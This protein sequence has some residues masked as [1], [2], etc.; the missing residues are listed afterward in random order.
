MKPHNHYHKKLKT[1]KL[2]A[3]HKNKTNKQQ[4]LFTK[5]MKPIPTPTY[6][7]HLS[8]PWFSLISL[9]LKTV[10]GRKN[11]GIFKSLAVGDTIEWHNEDFKP[12]S[13]LT[14]VVRKTPYPT[15]RE[16]LETEGLQKCLPGMPSVEHGLSVYFKYFTKEQEREFGVMAIELELVM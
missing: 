1:R 5:T 2:A 4:I 3:H 8:E 16:Y 6:R 12:R 7:E 15:F 11:K 13:V 10:E 14:R 9:G